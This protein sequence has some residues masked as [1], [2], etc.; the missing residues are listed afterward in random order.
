MATTQ[1]KPHVIIRGSQ[2]NI[3]NTLTRED[4][5]RLARDEYARQLCKFT[6]NQLSRYT[7]KSHTSSTTKDS[8]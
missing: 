8:V 7:S 6:A 5:L 1:S 3:T 4:L 2:A